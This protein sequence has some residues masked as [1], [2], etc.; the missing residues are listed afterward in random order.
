MITGVLADRKPADLHIFRNYESPEEVL[1]VDKQSIF[2]PPPRPEEQLL[3]RAARAT[4]A[5]PS[6]FR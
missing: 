2:V 3:W 4:G 6:Y 5:A 1:H